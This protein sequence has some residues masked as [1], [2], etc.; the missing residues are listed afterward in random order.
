MKNSKIKYPNTPHFKNNFPSSDTIKIG[1][2]NFLNDF[3][4]RNMNT[5][6]IPLFLTFFQQKTSGYFGQR[7]SWL[8]D[9]PPF[10][11][12]FSLRQPCLYVHSSSPSTVRKN[13]M[14]GPPP[15]TATRQGDCTCS[16]CHQDLI[17][18][19]VK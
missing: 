2:W 5:I 11:G 6:K 19:Q 14:T 8:D 7:F 3:K 13:H 17:K 12:V 15:P 18:L 1:R 10:T 16:L 4:V 9:L